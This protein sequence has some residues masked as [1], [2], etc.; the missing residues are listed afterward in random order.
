MQ[1][2]VLTPLL[3]GLFYKYPTYGFGLYGLLHALSAAAR[4]SSTLDNRLSVVVFHGMK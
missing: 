2:F 4:F 3:V 1:L